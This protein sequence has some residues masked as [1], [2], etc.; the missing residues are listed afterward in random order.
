MYPNLYDN[1]GNSLVE[2]YTQHWNS[3]TT[4]DVAMFI[5][6]TDHYNSSG[7]TADVEFDLLVPIEGLTIQLRNNKEEG[8]SGFPKQTYAMTMFHQLWCLDTLR[9]AHASRNITYRVQHCLNYLRQT[10]LCQCDLHLEAF[11][12]QREPR[13]L[14]NVPIDY[15]CRDW[16]VVYNKMS[17]MRALNSTVLHL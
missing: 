5:D 9:Q 11:Y 16:S 14:V 3:P 17:E 7:P 6:E 2:L 15:R 1:V 13:V 4:P 10:F 12:D 8:E